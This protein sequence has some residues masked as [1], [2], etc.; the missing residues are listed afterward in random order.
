MRQR[1][2]DSWSLSLLTTACCM[3][4]SLFFQTAYGQDPCPGSNC[5]SGDIRITRV[6]LV[7]N[8]ANH[9]PL[10]NTCTPGQDNV[11]VALKVDFDVT[12]TTRYGFLVTADVYGNPGG[13]ALVKIGK[14]AK[15][16]SKDYSQG[17]RVEYVDTYVGGAAI[18][19]ACGSRIQLQN[20]YTAWDN[21]APNT[22]VCGF[23]NT[24]TGAITNCKKIAPKCRFY[25]PTE[26]FDVIS[27]LIADFTSAEGSCT[28][29]NRTWTFTSTTTGG[30]TPYSYTWNFGDGTT[31][32]P[33]TTNPV[34]HDY[35]T[36]GAF[37]VTLTVTDGASGTATQTDGQSKN[38]SVTTCCVGSTAPTEATT[39]NNNF[40]SGGSTTL[41]INGG[42]LG[43]GASWK[44]YTGGCGT[45]NGG[46]LV[47]TGASFLVSPTTTTVY[48]VRAEGT[49][50][51]TIC[52]SVTVT[53]KPVP[54]KP[55]ISVENN[56]G[57]ST[58]TASGEAGA[59]FTWND[60]STTNPRT[61]TSGGSFT[62][63]QT[64]NGCTSQASD[65]AAAAPKTIP[66][67]PTIA[68][69]NN[70]DGTSTL[71]VSGLDAGATVNWTDAPTNHSNPRSVSVAG[72]YSATQTASNGCTGSASDAAA[73]APNTNPSTPYIKIITSPSCSS[74][75]GTLRVKVSDQVDY[76]S[77]YEFSNGGSYQN[78]PDF[79]FTAGGGYNITV[80]R[81][82]TNCTSSASCAA[83]GGTNRA[84]STTS[85]LSTISETTV[86]AYPNPF[87]DRIKFLVNS[88][89]AGRGSLDIYNMMGQRVKTVYQG[90]IGAGSQTF[91]LSMP[92]QQIANLIYV[93]RIGDKKTSGKI[94]QINQ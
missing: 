34:T 57:S 8:N 65:A 36:S 21:Q 76:T 35:S 52:R 93:L 20:V 88:S 12:S 94:L 5:V 74:S 1:K 33:T 70:C 31:L 10:P 4:M 56:C 32:G 6:T 17:P 75:T 41:G 16:Y 61:V 2:I 63:I 14:I 11:P 43:T 55:S 19:W 3:I 39:S 92:R 40:C 90:Y 9:S 54:G 49:C 72:N 67:K 82:G 83:E 87:S 45:E 48:Y 59:S 38:I 7:Q 64:V 69:Q 84:S 37:T 68:V 25:G 85:E 51:T 73:A 86:K 13:G 18:L 71:T 53:V 46:T 44:W 29:L 77:D 30:Q 58:L 80:R 79:T 26:S 27:P 50:G 78:S 89:S 23:L 24:S 66:G 91:E 28:N 22:T 42:S 60:N 81:K 47:H 15:C 62:V